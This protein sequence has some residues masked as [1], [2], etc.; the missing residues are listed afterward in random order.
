MIE[1]THNELPEETKIPQEAVQESPESK[2][3]ESPEG[4]SEPEPH[5][6]EQPIHEPHEEEQE[7]HEPASELHLEGLD[8]AGIL[9]ELQQFAQV[10]DMRALD[11]ALKEIKPNYDALYQE[12]KNIAL[13][14][15]V[16]SG[17]EEAD[18]QYKGDATDN[19]FFYLYNTLR[20]KKQKFFSQLEKDKDVNLHRKNEI[21]DKIR[22]LVDGEETNASIGKI[23]ELQAEWKRLGPVPG[24]FAK[25]LWANYNALLD[26]F[27]DNRSIYFEL[28]EL[29]RKKNLE[30]KLELCVKVETLNQLENIKDAIV[31]LNELHEEFKHIGPVPAEDQEPVW[32]RFKQASDSIY[33]KRKDFFEEL[34]SELH[35][36]M[37]Q[38]LVLAEEL[39]TFLDFNSDRISDWNKKTKDILEI[40]K[41]WDAIGGLPREKAKEI[42]RMFWSSFKQFF[43]NKNTFFKQLESEREGNMTIKKE[44]LAKAEELKNSE[45][46]EKASNELKQLQNK[47]REVGPVPERF[48]NEIYEKFKKACDHFF[49]RKRTES[50]GSGQTKDFEANLRRKN[51]ICSMLEAYLNSEVIELDQVYDLLNQYSDI[52]F[53]PKTAIKDIHDRFDSITQKLLSL[54]GLSDQ[55]RF[56]LEMKVEVNKLKNSPHGSQKINR[57]ESSI[58][59][60][61]STLESEINTW[62]T[63]VEF[64]ADSKTGNKLRD[65]FKEKIELATKEIE[66]LKKQLNVFSNL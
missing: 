10:E 27:Y 21:L 16:K 23:K 47:W 59:K 14:A 54:E 24:Q 52:G 7:T 38:K 58:R 42:N 40:Q 25:T 9:K 46:W 35:K 61:I 6:E 57:K 5:E 28:K 4:H 2:T 31:Q 36:N 45:D 64:F 19:S 20:D 37:E 11:K 49:E 29:D 55:Q 43:A 34:K 56:E 3:E 32:Q 63:N 33:A 65:D 60:R 13:Q 12:E 41:K 17:N 39:K 44:L 48:R 26:R 15:F 18:F 62:K 1:D 50:T 8:K 51:D 22:H 30:A 53:V 66:E